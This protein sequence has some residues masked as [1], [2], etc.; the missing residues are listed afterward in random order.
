M[1]KCLSLILSL[2]LAFP[3][4]AQSVGELDRALILLRERIQFV[5]SSTEAAVIGFGEGTMVFGAMAGLAVPIS[6]VYEPSRW[7]W[8]P[9]ATSG[10]LPNQFL[11]VS[12]GLLG[13]GLAIKLYGHALKREAQRR[14]KTP[15]PVLHYKTVEGLNE[16]MGLTPAEQLKVASENQELGEFLIHLAESYRFVLKHRL[17]EQG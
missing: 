12:A 6:H 11:W 13:A 8:E 1:T 3:G 16:F 15:P 5:D 4:H 7:S 17:P 9:Y 10:P 2:G 14:P